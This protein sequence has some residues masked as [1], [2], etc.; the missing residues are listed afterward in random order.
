M[1][2]GPDG[3]VLPCQ[4]WVHQRQPLGNILTTPWSRIWADPLCKRIRKTSSLK[5]DC[6][7]KGEV[8]S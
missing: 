8:L 7:L 6:P 4:S 1:A 2:I 3:E 5:N